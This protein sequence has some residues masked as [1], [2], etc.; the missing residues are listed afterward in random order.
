[1]PVVFWIMVVVTDFTIRNFINMNKAQLALGSELRTL[2]P[3]DTDLTGMREES[4]PTVEFLLQKIKS[5]K[6]KER[7][8]K[9]I[10]MEKRIRLHTVGT[11]D[12][13]TGYDEWLKKI[14]NLLPTDKYEIFVQLI[15]EP[16][17]TLD[18]TETIFDELAK[19]FEAS[20]RS[21]HL[22]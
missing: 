20:N 19:I 11:Q 1:M 6:N 12:Y 3:Q 9:G 15:G 10:E 21:I 7:I 22:S 13:S 5:P 8:I 17:P 14:K 4:R 18:L 16:V 2:Q